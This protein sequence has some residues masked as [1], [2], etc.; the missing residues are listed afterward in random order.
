MGMCYLLCFVLC[1][2]IV[3]YVLSTMKLLVLNFWKY[4]KWFPM[5]ALGLGHCVHY[6]LCFS[7]WLYM[8]TY[9]DLGLM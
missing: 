2:Q 9:W 6:E 8:L 3:C 4:K 1:V 5:F 7:L